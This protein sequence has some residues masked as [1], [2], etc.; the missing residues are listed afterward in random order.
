M[1][2]KAHFVVRWNFDHTDQGTVTIDRDSG[3]FS[4]RPFRRH[5]AYELPLS[6][7]AQIVAERCAKAEALA[8]RLARKN[9]KRAK[10]LVCQ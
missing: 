7:V 3:V 6:F 4:V 1:A 10:R 2:G 5:S 8:K 9:R